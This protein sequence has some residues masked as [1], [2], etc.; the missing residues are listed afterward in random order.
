M[1]HLLGACYSC[2]A[3]SI[4]VSIFGFIL[5][6]HLS[7]LESGKLNDFCRCREKNLFLCHFHM[8]MII[9]LYNDGM[10]KPHLTPGLHC[11]GIKQSHSKRPYFKDTKI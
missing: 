10:Y 5:S 7:N 1:Q 4:K 11:I 2:C 6:S 8:I 3:P 9:Y